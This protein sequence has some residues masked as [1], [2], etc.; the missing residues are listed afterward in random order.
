MHRWSRGA[1]GILLT[2]GALALLAGCE[3]ILPPTTAPATSEPALQDVGA[4]PPLGADPGLTADARRL[5]LQDLGVAR[6]IPV[7]L[8]DRREPGWATVYF[9]DDTTIAWCTVKRTPQGSVADGSSGTQDHW[10]NDAGIVTANGLGIQTATR[11][12]QPS[13]WSNVSGLLPRGATRIRA[14]VGGRAVD[15]V[16]G[17]GIYSV[18]W[19]GGLIPTVLVALDPSGQEVARIDQAGLAT[20]WTDTCPPGSLGCP[21]AP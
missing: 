2:A 10:T 12:G 7:V 3:L 1:T 6:D 14:V 16:V 17:A 18:S 21:P 9:A 5:C 19:P 20:I 15:A 8:Q 4:W 13:E 11:A